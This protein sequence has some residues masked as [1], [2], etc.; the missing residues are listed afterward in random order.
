MAISKDQV[1][2]FSSHIVTFV[3]GIVAF[4]STNQVAIEKFGQDISLVITSVTTLIALTSAL[5]AAWSASPFSHLQSVAKNP[6]VA[7]IVVIDKTLADKLP[8]KVV[9][10]R[11]LL[12][13]SEVV[14]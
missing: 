6:E 5:W 1:T 3:A 4:A 8:A 9:A 12:G 7:Q 11:P 10:L 14:I 13:S 2:S